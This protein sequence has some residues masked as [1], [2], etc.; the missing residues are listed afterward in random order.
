MQKDRWLITQPNGRSYVV[1][2]LNK[3]SIALMCGYMV[4]ALPHS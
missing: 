4:E 2:D 3:V 1:T